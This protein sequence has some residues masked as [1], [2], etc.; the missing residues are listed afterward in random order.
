MAGWMDGARGKLSNNDAVYLVVKCWCMVLPV[1]S[2]RR[3][4]IVGIQI[5][6]TCSF[7][8]EQR[9]AHAQPAVGLGKNQ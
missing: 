1:A 4:L 6:A 3:Y 2:E 9:R 7:V 5:R 8:S